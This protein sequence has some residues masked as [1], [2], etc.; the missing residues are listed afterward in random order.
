M[1]LGNERGYTKMNKYRERIEKSVLVAGLVAA[2]YFMGLN[3]NPTF[4][5]LPSKAQQAIVGEHQ[6]LDTLLTHA[7]DEYKKG[8]P[9]SSFELYTQVKRK[10]ESLEKIDPQ[11]EKFEEKFYRYNGAIID[12]HNVI[13]YMDNIDKYIVAG[14]AERV[15]E[16]VI[17]TGSDIFADCGRILNTLSQQSVAYLLLK[18]DVEMQRALLHYFVDNSRKRCDALEQMRTK[19]KSIEHKS[20][21]IKSALGYLD[22]R[23]GDIQEYR[24]QIDEFEQHNFP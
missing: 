11:Y 13:K 3:Q 2:S 10:A 6:D 20:K 9:K 22:S 7:V 23:K 1:A 12:T 17:W 18:G 19:L 5:E 16:F 24:K 14:T 8:N 21:K 15:A 4:S